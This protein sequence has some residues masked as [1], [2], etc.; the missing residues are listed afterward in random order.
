MTKRLTVIVSVSLLAL[1]ASGAAAQSFRPAY[2]AGK[3]E[4]EEDL[5][6][7][8]DTDDDDYIQ[9]GPSGLC[10]DAE[11]N[12]FIL[13]Y[14]MYW[15]RKY[16]A[17]GGHM[18]TFSRQ[19]EGPGELQRAYYVTI[20][21]DG[22]PVVF[23]SGNHRITVFDNDGEFVRD[24]GLQGF[25][26]SIKSRPDGS[27]CITVDI[28]TDEWME[29]G[30]L[31]KI[32][33]LS[34]DLSTRTDIDSSYV[35]ETQML[36]ASENSYTSVSA[37]FP[38]RLMCAVAPEGEL[39]DGKGDEYKLKVLSSGLDQIAEIKLDVGRLGVTDDD[40]EE[41]YEGFQNSDDPNFEIQLRKNVEF[42]RHKPYF[43]RIFV[44]HEGYVL[45]ETY[46]EAE[47]EDH[48]VYDVFTLAGE[49]INRVEIPPLR[50]NTIFRDGFLYM[51]HT[52]E[53]ELPSVIRYRLKSAP[54]TA[55]P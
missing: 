3:V 45:V 13:D 50:S 5:V 55:D 48:N 12:I 1:L 43:N 25:V 51:T 54:E 38:E 44:D 10:V 16:N 49:F 33:L 52:E 24:R 37:P 39:V 28:M 9:Y 26:G 53:D 4:F 6:I 35:K 17:D 41:Y 8:G 18:R 19:G 2:E 11:G 46:A 15:I 32:L 31:K 40:K 34:N 29:K 14:R 23:D 27:L 36:H 7:G 22:S 47:S 20:T 42:P 21:P 30:Q